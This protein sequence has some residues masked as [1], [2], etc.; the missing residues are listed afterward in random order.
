M[1]GRRRL[2]VC[3]RREAV[4][5]TGAEKANAGSIG[6]AIVGVSGGLLRTIG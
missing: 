6:G 5:G 1:F 2:Q 4:V 3:G